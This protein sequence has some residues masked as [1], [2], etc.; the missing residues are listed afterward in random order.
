MTETDG[1]VSS[2]AVT[3]MLAGDVMTGRAI[4]QVL[5]HPSPPVLYEPEIRSALDYVRLAEAANG[6]IE[7][8]VSFP[9]I[10]GDALAVLDRRRPDLRIVNLETAVTQSRR[11]VLKGINFRMNPDNLPC[12]TAAGLDCCVLANNHVLDWRRQG[13]EETLAVLRDAGIPTAGAGRDA[14]E[15]SA[16]AILSVPGKGRVLVYGFACPS[17]GV[18]A[19]WAAGV[20]VSGVSYVEQPSAA[21]A[22][23]IAERIGRNRRPGDLVIVSIHWGGNWGY[24]IPEND[25]AFAHRLIEAGAADIIHGHS[26]HHCKAIEVY[27][28]KPIFYGC[29]DLINDYEG[30]G[31]YEN[32]RSE[33]A[34]IYFV[35]MD[36]GGLVSLDMVPFRIRNF[37]LNRT[38]DEE[39]E[40]L[41]DIM[42]R[43][44]AHFGGSVRL[45]DSG[46]LAL[47][48]S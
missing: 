13:L 33:L 38:N 24:D 45:S 37:R 7:Q 15:A 16:P 17:S 29:G 43:E 22:Q 8:P 32:Y 19:D 11:I 6:P 40:W 20:D 31:R 2:S 48:W 35:A 47:S 4:D 21:S 23:A 14:G 1:R 12:L 3:L 46:L 41:R 28:G 36:G 5:P 10:W 44:C 34:L 26:S 42:D 9:Y 18:P 30:I 25:R 27:R 39:A